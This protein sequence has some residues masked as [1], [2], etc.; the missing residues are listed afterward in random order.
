VTI[1]KQQ[2]ER[3]RQLRVERNM[4]QDEARKIVGFGRTKS[5]QL[6]REFGLAGD[7]VEKQRRRPLP[8]KTASL[9]PED[10]GAIEDAVRAHERSGVI[11]PVGHGADVPEL[12][13]PLDLVG[14]TV[15]RR[16]A[17]LFFQGERETES[18]RELG[19]SVHPDDPF[20]AR[21]SG[22][23]GSPVRIHVGRESPSDIQKFARMT[24]HR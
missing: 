9:S 7:A 5:W 12:V 19:E 18:V 15:P 4:S 13:I 17:L 21:S 16:G 8:R 14:T 22:A 20:P 24:S 6:D 23:P 11:P 1:S 2:K 10:T 3:Y